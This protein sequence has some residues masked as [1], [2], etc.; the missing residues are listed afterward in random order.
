MG[1]SV[2]PTVFKINPFWDE[3]T[4]YPEEYIYVLIIKT[5]KQ[6]MKFNVSTQSNVLSM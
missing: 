3:F 2:I 4:R 1:I 6:Y 5:Y